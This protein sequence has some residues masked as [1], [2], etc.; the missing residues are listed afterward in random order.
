MTNTASTLFITLYGDL[1]ATTDEIFIDNYEMLYGNTPKLYTGLTYKCAGNVITNKGEIIN[2]K[3]DVN[4]NLLNEG[5]D[6]LCVASVTSAESELKSVDAVDASFKDSEVS[7]K[8][9]LSLDNLPED[10][11]SG[12]YTVRIFIWEQGSFIP[13]TS[14]RIV[15]E[16]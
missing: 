4:F 12:D 14:E 5:K 7:K 8:V 16:K 11:S 13:L 10:I 1:N 9:N 2:N 6:V 3:I 15:L